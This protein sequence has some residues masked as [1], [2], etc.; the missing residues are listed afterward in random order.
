MTAQTATEEKSQEES[1]S[2]PVN[3]SV[4][5]THG[6]AKDFLDILRVIAAFVD[7]AKLTFTAEGM[8]ARHMDPSHVAMVDLVLPKEAFEDYEIIG[9]EAATVTVNIAEILKV[10]PRPAIDTRL[11]L[12]M[13]SETK[14]HM[15]R[16][17]EVQTEEK[18]LTIGLQPY[19]EDE[20]VY[21]FKVLEDSNEEIPEPKIQFHATVKIVTKVF[22]KKLAARGTR[23]AAR[24][25][26][27]ASKRSN[28]GPL[29][30]SG[31]ASACGLPPAVK[32][33]DI[34]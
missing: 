31:R 21:T 13:T 10:L 3:G 28:H 5:A 12:R 8:K 24:T 32:S 17:K 25:A 29:S 15:R 16:D 34:G 19:G 9:G 33:A 30:W 2:P 18:E 14:T 27:V 7:E 22:T 26:S 4:K 11:A 1:K 23:A 20:N 6:S